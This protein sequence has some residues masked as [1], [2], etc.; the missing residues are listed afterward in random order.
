VKLQ[1]ISIMFHIL[2]VQLLWAESEDKGRSIIWGHFSAN[3]ERSLPSSIASTFYR[4]SHKR[5]VL[6]NTMSS[7]SERPLD[8][9]HATV[10]DCTQRAR[11]A[12]TST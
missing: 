6:H 4:G 8:P 9:G 5:F 12:R 7:I 11:P 1:T 10:E 2:H 3:A